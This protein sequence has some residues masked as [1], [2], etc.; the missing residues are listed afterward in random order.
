MPRH[1]ADELRT[2]DPEKIRIGETM[3]A[4]V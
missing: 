4:R 2:S 3:L 1:L